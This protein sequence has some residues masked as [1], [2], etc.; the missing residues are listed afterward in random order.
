MMTG[1]ATNADPV[2]DKSAHHAAL[3]AEVDR[4]TAQPL[5][6]VRAK[7]LLFRNTKNSRLLSD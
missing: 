4:I 3:V 5:D 6:V 7:P 1:D 2:C